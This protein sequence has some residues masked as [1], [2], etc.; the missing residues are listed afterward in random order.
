MENTEQRIIIF[1]ITRNDDR[2][3]VLRVYYNDE[4]ILKEYIFEYPHTRVGIDYKKYEFIFNKTH[5]SDKGEKYFLMKFLF[6]VMI[7]NAFH[8]SYKEIY[9]DIPSGYYSCSIVI[10]GTMAKLLNSNTNWNTMKYFFD[11]ENESIRREEAHLY[12]RKEKHIR[13]TMA[14]QGSKFWKNFLIKKKITHIVHKDV[15]KQRHNLFSSNKMFKVKGLV[16]YN[17]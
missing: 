10:A 2:Q 16:C 7:Y 15:C 4:V 8:T 3:K 1:K 11:I 13:G 5:T 12:I 14:K 9:Y 17:K 6:M